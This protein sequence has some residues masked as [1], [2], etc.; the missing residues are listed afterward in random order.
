VPALPRPLT[1][2]ASLAQVS[3]AALSVESEADLVTNTVSTK[4]ANG[5]TVAR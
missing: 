3:V 5:S 2:L 4:L 1:A